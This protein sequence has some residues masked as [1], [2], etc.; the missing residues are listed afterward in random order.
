VSLETLEK[1]MAVIEHRVNELDAD[2]HRIRDRLH[3]LESDRGTLK[4][5]VE[6][7]GNLVH[8]MEAVAQRTAEKTV[9]AMLE[10]RAAGSRS[11]REHFLQW[12][13]FAVAVIVTYFALRH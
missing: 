13:Q 10:Q 5:V 11:W 6:Q 9:A 4:L 8:N 3:N 12:A 2:R 1:Q 7:M